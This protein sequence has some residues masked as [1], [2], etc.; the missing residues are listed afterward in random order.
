MLTIL[1]SYINMKECTSNTTPKTVNCTAVTAG[2]KTPQSQS[3]G[4]RSVSQGGSVASSLDLSL[5][6][7]ASNSN[8]SPS[9]NQPTASKDKKSKK[10][11]V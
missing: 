6:G 10:K 3:I 7:V 11:K 5:E 8:A 9:E 1:T 4:S 2:N